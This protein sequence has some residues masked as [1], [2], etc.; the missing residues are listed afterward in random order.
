[1]V[2]TKKLLTTEE[3][4]YKVRYNLERRLA[5]WVGFHKI[6]K[7]SSVDWW[8]P[9]GSHYGSFVPHFTTSLEDCFKYL[10]PKVTK[11]KR[12]SL[13]KF[14]NLDLF[15]IDIGVTIQIRGTNLPLVICLGVE[16]LIN[17]ESTR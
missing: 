7:E 3:L 11:T 1:M 17:R 14:P 10:V 13:S 4:P 15:Q 9:D 2:D 16:K 8:T 6:D 12:F 5:K